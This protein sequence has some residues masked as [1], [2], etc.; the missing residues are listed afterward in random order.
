M[1]IYVVTYTIYVYTYIH[2]SR[3]VQQVGKQGGRQVEGKMMAII[4][5]AK[6]G[7]NAL[8]KKQQQQQPNNRARLSKTTGCI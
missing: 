4:E 3:Q 6:N 7:K 5:I 1:M 8:A 2:G